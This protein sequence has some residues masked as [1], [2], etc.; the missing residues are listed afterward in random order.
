MSPQPATGTR[1][2]AR[3]VWLAKC[4][5]RWPWTERE[6]R[7]YVYVAVLEMVWYYEYDAP[8]NTV[9]VHQVM[10]HVVLDIKLALVLFKH[11]LFAYR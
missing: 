10:S 5:P 3:P 11:V 6:G 1:E 4:G 9:C 7:T 2:R 8:L